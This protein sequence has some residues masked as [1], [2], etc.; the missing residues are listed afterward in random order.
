MSR[1]N[2][3]AKDRASKLDYNFEIFATLAKQPSNNFCAFWVCNCIGSPE[4][5]RNKR[6]SSKSNSCMNIHRGLSRACRGDHSSDSC[7]LLFWLLSVYISIYDIYIIYKL[8]I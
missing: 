3:S 6:E 2:L 8:Y 4:S 1:L 7:I 5:S